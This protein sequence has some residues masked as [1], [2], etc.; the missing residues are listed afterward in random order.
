MVFKVLYLMLFNH[1]A[2]TVEEMP[3]WLTWGGQLAIAIVSAVIPCIFSWWKD[4]DLQKQIRD[5]KSQ[6][7]KSFD[8]SSFADE[9]NELHTKLNQ[10]Q[11]NL[12][13]R[14]F[15]VGM[16]TLQSL[17]QILVRIQSYSKRVPFKEDDQKIIDSYL[18]EVKQALQ[19]K[20]YG[21]ISVTANG[22]VE[23]IKLILEKGAYK[24]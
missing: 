10:W 16:V 13:T 11:K 21:K 17:E 23:E 4:R 8:K 7:S 20:D 12:C 15:K 19:N 24:I 18:E 14:H 5:L 2:T 22:K 1:A 6:I 3:F 9:R